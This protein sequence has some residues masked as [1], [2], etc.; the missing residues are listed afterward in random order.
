MKL[1][2][3]SACE[4]PPL[5]TLTRQ[6]QPT[7]A[8]PPREDSVP[9]I[10]DSVHDVQDNS[11]TVHPPL[12]SSISHANSED[13]IPLITTPRL[14]RHS[15][16]VLSPG[17]RLLNGTVPDST[18]QL[19]NLTRLS[20]ASGNL[21]FPGVGAGTPRPQQPELSSWSVVVPVLLA[22]LVCSLLSLN[23]GY[24]VSNSIAFPFLLWESHSLWCRWQTFLTGSRGRSGLVVVALMLSGVSQ[25]TISIFVVIMNMI[26]C[27]VED[28]FLYIFTV[29]MWYNMVG[30]PNT[31]QGQAEESKLAFTEQVLDSNNIDELHEF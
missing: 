15:P 1:T 8:L 19:L 3:F 21:A 22:L 13:S 9:P 26:K 17:S 11:A 6:T 29:V 18:E 4:D 16:T 23:L 5:P 2:H 28:F 7:K 27:F 30:F 20:A 14:E 24:I 25:T 12:V 10:Q 31:V